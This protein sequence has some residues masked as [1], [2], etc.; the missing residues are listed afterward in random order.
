[1][2][3]YEYVKIT[4]KVLT[5][6]QVLLAATS[7]VVTVAT[8][9]TNSTYNKPVSILL[10][11]LLLRKIY[12]LY[13]E[14]VNHGGSVQVPYFQQFIPQVQIQQIQI[15]VF[16]YSGVSERY[17]FYG[18]FLSI[19]HHPNMIDPERFVTFL[20]DYYQITENVSEEL[21]THLYDEYNNHQ[22]LPQ[23][24]MWRSNANSA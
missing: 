6:P 9:E 18:N 21:R 19:H 8:L 13:Y 3:F 12:D 10:G 16:G 14:E 22:F 2:K 11:L 20:N 15:P 23:Y 24:K 17:L 1:M 5:E 4:I 7:A